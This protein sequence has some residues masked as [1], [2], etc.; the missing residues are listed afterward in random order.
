M[1]SRHSHVQFFRLVA[2]PIAAGLIVF[3][4]AS[5]P[6]FAQAAPAPYTADELAYQTGLSGATA[7]VPALFL[8]QDAMSAR[9]SAVDDTT[10]MDALQADLGALKD[11]WQVVTDQIDALRTPARYASASLHMQIATQS[12]AIAYGYLATGLATADAYDIG[13]GTSSIA[14]AKTRLNEAGAEF[15]VA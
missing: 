3:V 11:R 15:S 13:V 4:P 1:T 10:D 7:D 8:E 5:I 9:V 14:G 2:G 6:A 12:Y